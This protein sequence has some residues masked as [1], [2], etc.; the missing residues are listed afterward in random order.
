MSAALTTSSTDFHYF[1][2][3]FGFAWARSL[4]ATRF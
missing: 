2:F 3:G 4:A 1:F